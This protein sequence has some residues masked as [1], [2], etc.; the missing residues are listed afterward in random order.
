MMPLSPTILLSL[1]AGCAT[2][3]SAPPDPGKVRQYSD[4]VFQRFQH[5]ESQHKEPGVAR[6]TLAG[7][8]AAAAEEVTNRLPRLQDPLVASLVGYHTSLRRPCVF[9]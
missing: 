3:S 5:E 6:G 4:A 1:L 9:H 7:T 8:S 2:P